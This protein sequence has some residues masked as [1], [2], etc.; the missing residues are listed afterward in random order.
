VLDELPFGLF[1]EIEGS[2]TDIELAEI[3]LEAESFT[4]EH[5][6]YPSLT[7]QLGLQNGDVFEARF[8]KKS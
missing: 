3:M 6:T 5:A 2:I 7:A 1:M 4:T 8:A